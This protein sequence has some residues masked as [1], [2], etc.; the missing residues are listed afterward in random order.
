MLLSW[1]DIAFSCN[2]GCYI[3]DIVPKDRQTMSSYS[4]PIPWK[5]IFDYHNQLFKEESYGV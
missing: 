1:I 4:I 2:I 3:P 5:T